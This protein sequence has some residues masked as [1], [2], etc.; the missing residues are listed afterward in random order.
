MT[1]TVK[2]TVKPHTPP[3]SSFQNDWQ[4]SIMHLARF[5]CSNLMA[6]VEGTIITGTLRWLIGGTEVSCNQGWISIK[7]RSFPLQGFKCRSTGGNCHVA[8]PE[9]PPLPPWLGT[10]SFA[11]RRRRRAILRVLSFDFQG[12]KPK[13]KIW[14]KIVPL[15]FLNVNNVRV[16]FF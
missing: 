10:W 12:K 14:T 16:V 5:S 13:E 9:L 7:L 3:P 4:T 1:L 8:H 11:H 6:M 15:H 2:S